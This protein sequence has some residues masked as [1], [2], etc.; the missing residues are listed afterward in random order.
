MATTPS[1]KPVASELPQDLKFNS[2]KIDE[3]VT[4]MGWTYTDR[5]GNKHYTIEGIN[6]L[7]QQVMNAFGYITLTGVDFDT[8]ATISTPNEALFNPDDNSYY[9]WTGSFATGPKVVPP[10]STPASSGGVGPGK[11]LNVGD[12]VLRSQ[13]AADGGAG[14][15]GTDSGN[16]VQVE[17]DDINGTMYQDPLTK[18]ADGGTLKIKQGEYNITSSLVMDYGLFPAKFPGA[19][20]V[21]NHYEGENMAETIFNCNLSTFAMQMKGDNTYT[22]QRVH[23]YDYLGGFTLNGT[24]NSYG[25]LIQ[26]KAYTKLSDILC[27]SHTNGEGIRI[28]NVITSNMHDIYSQYNNIGIRIIG[29]GVSGGDM[30]A[31]TMERI[32]ASNN[33]AYGIYGERWGASNVIT[34]L[35]CEGNGSMSDMNSGGMIV[36]LAGNFTCPALV[37]NNPYFELNKG[38]ADLSITNTSSTKPL[39]V[40]INGGLFNRGSPTE[41]T[42]TNI[43]ISS[44]GGAT[45]VILIGTAFANTAGYTPSASRPYWTKGTNCEVIPIGCVYDDLTAASTAAQSMVYSGRVTAAGAMGTASANFTATSSAAGVY[46]VVYNEGQLGTDIGSFVVMATPYAANADVT[47]ETTS[48]STTSFRVIIRNSGGSGVA[49]SFNWMVTRIL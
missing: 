25:L 9:K 6:Y 19:A 7:A 40:I 45:K 42:K 46:T 24:A 35:T 34:G 47:I 10:N 41:Y 37:L 39:T 21:R 17:L 36:N 4:S 16:T 11:W 27:L 33:A 49:C 32:T 13:L 8:G 12:T 30:N 23:T 5:F 15:I 22:S 29:D 1:Q 44:A 28:Q 14:M 20:G 2:G 26:G 18:W 3:F 31:V 43:S 38:G 48:L